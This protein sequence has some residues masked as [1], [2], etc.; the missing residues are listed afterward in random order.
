MAAK[1]ITIR[2][3]QVRKDFKHYTKTFGNF[4]YGSSYYVFFF[5]L[6]NF[7]GSMPSFE[8][9]ENQTRI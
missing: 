2:V 3:R 4:L 9:L 6:L 5:C 1:K 7:F 8:D